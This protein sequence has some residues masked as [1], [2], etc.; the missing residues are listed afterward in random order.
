[1]C[2][3]FKLYMYC[4]YLI[5]EGDIQ[6]MYTTLACTCTYGVHVCMIHIRLEGKMPANMH[7]RFISTLSKIIDL[8]VG[9]KIQ[10]V[11]HSIK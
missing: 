8:K 10:Q 7:N 1:M 3:Y 6:S 4:T 5:S 9:R 2:T 11:S